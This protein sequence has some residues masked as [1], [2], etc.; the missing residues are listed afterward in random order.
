MNHETAD[1]Q[2]SEPTP[3]DNAAWREWVNTF[4][5]EGERHE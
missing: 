3:A 5:P 4:M 2:Q 1:V